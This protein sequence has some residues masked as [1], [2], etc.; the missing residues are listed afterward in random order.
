MPAGKNALLFRLAGNKLYKKEPKNMNNGIERIQK[1][2]IHLLKLIEDLNTDDLNK[3]PVGFNNNIVWNIGHLI[4][5]QQSICYLRT[6]VQPFVD[7]KYLS[8]YKPGTKPLGILPEAD[9]LLM[10]ELFLE[11]IEQFG[12]DFDAGL[13]STCPHWTT[14]YGIEIH[15]ID[16]AINFDLFHEGLH[17]GYIMAMRRTLHV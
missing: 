6:G 7:E 12:T 3:I 5:S 17:R 16:D 4:A 13:F 11:A 2:R 9:I 1:T 10:K 14:G 8:L 15:N